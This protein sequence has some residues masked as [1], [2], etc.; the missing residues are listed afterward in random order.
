MQEA[1][2]R[3]DQTWIT[4]WL[5]FMPKACSL[6]CPRER[7]PPPSRNIVDIIRSPVLLPLPSCPQQLAS[8]RMSA[9]PSPNNTRSQKNKNR[10][11][12]AVSKG[13]SGIFLLRRFSSDPPPPTQGGRGHH[14]HHLRISMEGYPETD[15]EVVG[16]HT[17]SG[18]Q[19]FKS[20][21]GLPFRWPCGGGP[22]YGFLFQ[23]E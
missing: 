23:P 7:G 12:R 2:L 3:R 10:H 4:T 6:P 19:G 1:L 9:R 15:L 5:L 20:F 14:L 22:Q 8:L 11:L 18:T 21:S 17:E 13:L 16:G